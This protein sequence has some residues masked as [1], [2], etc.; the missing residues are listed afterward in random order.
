MSNKAGFYLVGKP[1]GVLTGQNIIACVASV[2]ARVRR[3]SRTRAK[4]RERGRERGREGG[5]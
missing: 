4:Q 2:S 3:E 5:G 1:S